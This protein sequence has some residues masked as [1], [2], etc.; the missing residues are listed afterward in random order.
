[1]KSIILPKKWQDG[2]WHNIFKADN[3]LK[4]DIRSNCLL[5]DFCD[6][7]GYKI[8][9]Q[10]SDSHIIISGPINFLGS[11]LNIDLSITNVGGVF[12]ATYTVVKVPFVS[13]VVTFRE[14][15]GQ[16]IVDDDLQDSRLIKRIMYQ[17]IATRFVN[18]GAYAVEQF[19]KDL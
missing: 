7:C 4:F 11:D 18:D 8:E 14:V 9:Q 6:Y 16:L 12:E 15:D 5:D 19:L 1:M 13:L 10:I 2:V 3:E 17:P